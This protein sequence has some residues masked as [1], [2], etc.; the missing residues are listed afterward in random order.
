ME[1]I[2]LNYG[3]NDIE[4]ED[5]LYKALKAGYA[6]DSARYAGG[7][8]LIPEDIELTMLNVLRE[9]QEDCKLMNMLKKMP[10]SSTVH[11][12]NL[13]EDVGNYE[14]IAVEEGAGSETN[15]Q[16]IRRVVR[17]I[18]FLQ[19]RRAV[20]DQMTLVHSFED[21][22][23]SEK[24]AG[25]FNVLRGAEYLCFHGNSDIV[26]AQFDGLLKQIEEAK[27]ANIV[28]MRG[29]SVGSFGESA[30]TEPVRQI[31]EKGGDANKLF[32]PPILAQDI[33]DLVKDRIRFGTDGST[34]HFGQT[35]GAD[36][37]FRPKGVVLP[38]GIGRTSRPSAPANVTVA[39]GADSASKFLA[40]DAGNYKYCVYA[41][42]GSGIS[43]GKELSGAAAVSAGN[44]V[45]L[46]IQASTDGKETGYIIARSAK[47]EDVLMEMVRIPKNSAGAVTTF[48]D[49][50][51]D[52]PGTA[53]MVLITERNIETV[54][55]WCQLCPM[56]VRPL[57]ESNRAE[58]PF[59][60]Q[61]FG[62]LDVKAP[63]WCAVVKNIQYKG[64]LVY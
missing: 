40:S 29:K 44:K 8:A 64:G 2:V 48:E 25:T 22:Y 60:V 14:D 20:S 47:N 31:Y 56:R 35:E 36:K 34:V 30:I 32:M 38:R 43:E 19:D 15:D 59:F 3:E 52:L 54:V 18:K 55:Q 63:Q 57:Y 53:K 9:R 21:A 5:A 16:S 11:E 24:I 13:R 10:V 62:A 61:L 7:R 58:M 41:I 6:T 26:P 46:S 49:L 42:N 4:S 27:D 1:D 39:T 45:T 17:P 23:A 37:F 28:D 51:E 12:Y 50:N 33:Q